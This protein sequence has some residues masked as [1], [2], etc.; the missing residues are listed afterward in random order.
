[1]TRH[2]ICRHSTDLEERMKPITTLCS[3]RMKHFRRLS[4]RV[5]I[6]LL[7]FVTV[8][9]ATDVGSKNDQVLKVTH[10]VGFANAPKNGKG[11]LVIEPD[12]LEFQKKGR[13][14]V[15]IK[16][17]SIADIYVGE[18]SKQLGGKPMAL[19]K[20]AIPYSGGRLVSLFAHAK[21]DLLTLEYRDTDEGFHEA[22]FELEKGEA[23]RFRNELVA[24]GALVSTSHTKSTSQIAGVSSEKQ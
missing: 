19:G 7:A 23:E 9:F 1:M 18:Q 8:T 6:S 21:R 4:V 3:T 20:A 22:V 15:Q 14:P 10:L 17:V 5:L 2:S 13:P 11:I 24:R 16:V 12:A